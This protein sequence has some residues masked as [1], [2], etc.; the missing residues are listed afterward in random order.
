MV[1]ATELWKRPVIGVQVGL[2]GGAACRE[3]ISDE[4]GRVLFV[5]SEHENARRRHC[6]TV[7]N[8]VEPSP[9]A[10]VHELCAAFPPYPELAAEGTG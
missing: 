10:C 6:G 2:D 8:G 1:V 9:E 3:R 7:P 5:M 4:P